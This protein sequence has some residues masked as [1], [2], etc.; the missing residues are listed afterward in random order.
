MARHH[1]YRHGELPAIG[2]LF[3][4]GNAV[5]IGHPNIQENQIG[6]HLL[7][8][9]SR[10]YRTFCCIDGVALIRQNLIEKLTNTHFIIDHQNTRHG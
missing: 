10:L 4:Q 3:K 8:H 9:G 7:A 6:A 5:R 1:Y 2:P